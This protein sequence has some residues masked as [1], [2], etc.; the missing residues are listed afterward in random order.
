VRRQS[1]RLVFAATPVLLLLALACQSRQFPE[2]KMER[3]GLEGNWNRAQLVLFG[4]LTNIAQVGVQSIANPSDPAWVADQIPITRVW[5]FR[6]RGGETRVRMYRSDFE[7]PFLPMEDENDA[8]VSLASTGWR[9]G[10][11]RSR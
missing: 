6:G 9:F 1:F 7:K 8:R 5:F 3:V 11:S 4:S 10:Q 2:V